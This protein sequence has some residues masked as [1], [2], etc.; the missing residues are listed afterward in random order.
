[1]SYKVKIDA[2]DGPFD[3]L[4]YLIESARMSIYD[5]QIAEITRQYL[6]YMDEAGMTDVESA[7]D[8]M[9]LAATLLDLKARMILPGKVESPEIG[10]E[11]DPRS[12]LVERLLAYKKCR[13]EAEALEQCLLREENVFE[14]ARE[15]ISSYTD[16]PDEI[17]NLSLDRFALAFQLFLARRETI[18]SVRQ[19]YET[20]ERDRVSMANKIKEIAAR[21]RHSIRAGKN[22]L[23]FSDLCQDRKDRYDLV[24]SFASILQMVKDRKLDADQ[25]RSFGEIYLRAPRRR[26]DQSK[27]GKDDQ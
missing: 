22:R 26:T 2:F 15:D 14:K 25:D 4:V 27:G 11:E 17:L 20:L 9:V 8:F 21:L 10:E 13:R 23:P 12:D 6:V 16:Q 7:G 3:L 24:V 19:R 18:H 1:M 5:I